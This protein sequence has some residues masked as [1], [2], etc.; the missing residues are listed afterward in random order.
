[1]PEYKGKPKAVAHEIVEAF[2]EGQPAF[3]LNKTNPAIDLLEEAVANAIQL[4]DMVWLKHLHECNSAAAEVERDAVARWFE[5]LVAS[6]K[7][8]GENTAQHDAFKLALQDIKGLEHIQFAMQQQGLDFSKIP[9]N[10]IDIDVPLPTLEDSPEAP[11]SGKGIRRKIT[12][13]DPS[14]D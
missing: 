4:R 7:V 14:L 6:L 5:F 3:V 12:G 13:N 9:D 10:P 11:L 1:M 2:R 8:E